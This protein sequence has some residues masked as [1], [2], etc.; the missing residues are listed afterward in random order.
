MIKLS[1]TMILTILLL[2]TAGPVASEEMI[3][4][5][6]A[7]PVKS[8]T[9][10]IG[11]KFVLIPSGSYTMGSQISPEEVV[12]RYGGDAKKAYRDEQ[13]PHPVKITK[14]FYLQT[15]E[16]TQGQWKK[17]MGDNPSSFK[18]C[19][20]DCPVEQCQGGLAGRFRTEDLHYPAPGHSSQTQSDVQREGTCGNDRY[21]GNG[22]V[23]AQSHDGSL[24]KLPF[25]L[26]HG[27]F[28][29]LLSF[30]CCGH[31]RFPLNDSFVGFLKL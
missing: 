27:Q 13:P 24:A 9:N 20:D 29:C 8:I 19:G 25:N 22:G 2:V 7:S 5:G 10:S 4:E 17:A 3:K 28:D 15:T 14:P 23:A 26:V 18:D 12:R 31:D 30:L 1:M 6:S 11:M 16:V 21:V